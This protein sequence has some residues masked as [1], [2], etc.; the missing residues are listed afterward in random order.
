MT[1]TRDS[2]Q[3]ASDKSAVHGLDSACQGRHGVDAPLS[4]SAVELPQLDSDA[5]PGSSSNQHATRTDISRPSHSSIDQNSGKRS[6]S[7]NDRLCGKPQL[8]LRLC[9]SDLFSVDPGKY[10]SS[11]SYHNANLNH[12][13]TLSENIALPQRPRMTGSRSSARR[14][15]GSRTTPKE[16]SLGFLSADMNPARKSDKNT[17]NTTKGKVF[18]LGRTPITRVTHRQPPKNS[19]RGLVITQRMNFPNTALGMAFRSNSNP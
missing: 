5:E 12:P 4:T 9:P 1:S 10:N 6:A 7:T 3:E 18:E 17:V 2:S 13:T 11:V 15:V 8:R 19:P 14:D 16:E